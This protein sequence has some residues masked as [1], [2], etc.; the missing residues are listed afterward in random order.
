MTEAQQMYRAGGFNEIA[1]YATHPLAG[2][3]CF[4]K[5]LD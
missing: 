4:G 3:L 5:S 2:T 1:P